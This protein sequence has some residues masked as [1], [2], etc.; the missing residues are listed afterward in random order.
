MAKKIFLMWAVALMALAFSAC[1]D[2]KNTPDPPAEPDYSIKYFY[3]LSCEMSVHGDKV[4]RIQPSAS[5]PG[6]YGPDIPIPTEHK[7]C[8]FLF[9]VRDRIVVTGIEYKKQDKT[10]RLAFPSTGELKICNGVSISALEDKSYGVEPDIHHYQVFTTE[11]DADNLEQNGISDL[12]ILIDATPFEKVY[13]KDGKIESTRFDT[14]DQFDGEKHIA[15]RFYPNTFTDKKRVIHQ[16][17]L[18]VY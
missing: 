2:D 3:G 12:R 9:T 14:E 17:Y 16:P 7:P 15:I 6:V 18:Y 11:F 5:T 1:S 10:I 4:Y 8:S 13:S